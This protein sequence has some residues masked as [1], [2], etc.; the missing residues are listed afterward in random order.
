MAAMKAELVAERLARAEVLA[1]LAEALAFKELAAH[2]ALEIAKLRHQL[3]GRSA[4][5]SRQIIDQLELA[6]VEA[7]GDATQA[8][9]VAEDRPDLKFDAYSPRFPERVREHDGDA[10]SAIREK[11]IIIHHPYES[12]EVVVDFLRQAAADPDVVAIKQTLSRAGSQSAVIGALIEAAEAGKSVTALVE[13]KARFDEEQ[14]LKWASALERAGV[15][16]IYGFTEW[17]T[18]AKVAMVVRV[19]LLPTLVEPT[20]VVVAVT[21]TE[22]LVVQLNRVVV[23]VAAVRV[24]TTTMVA[25]LLHLAEQTLEA[26]AVVQTT[27]VEE[28]LAVQELSSFVI[29]HQ[30]LQLLQLRVGAHQP[31]VHTR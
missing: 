20:Q 27:L 5:R 21:H 29:S 10:F 19:V 12:F 25:T 30:P 9:I 4:E 17:K 15:Q 11:D 22:T 1:Q 7:V 18:H 6:L 16:V 31:L 14:N 13:L 26:V 23:Q 24:Q 2:Q 8:E 28:M 3:Y